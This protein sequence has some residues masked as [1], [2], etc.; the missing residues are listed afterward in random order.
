M[1]V[2]NDFVFPLVPQA[3][4]VNLGACDIAAILPLNEAHAIYCLINTFCFKSH[5]CLSC[6]N[7]IDS[8]VIIQLNL[9]YLLSLVDTNVFVTLTINDLWVSEMHY[10][11]KNLQ[12]VNN[13]LPL[14]SM[15]ISTVPLL[16][17]VPKFN[18]C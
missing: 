18:S 10:L 17:P 15:I 11:R 1:V 12:E 16:C 8:A 4:T 9:Q 3:V 5:V 14:L 13:A 2:C 7:E 6:R